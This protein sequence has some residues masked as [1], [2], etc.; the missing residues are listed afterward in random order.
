MEKVNLADKLSL[1]ELAQLPGVDF[2]FF[3][4]SVMVKNRGTFPV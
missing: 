1:R 2:R 3:A 4:V